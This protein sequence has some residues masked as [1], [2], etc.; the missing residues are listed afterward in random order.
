MLWTGSVLLLPACLP[1]KPA[2][3]MRKPPNTRP[4]TFRFWGWHTKMFEWLASLISRVLGAAWEERVGQW[5]SMARVQGRFII[6]ATIPCVMDVTMQGPSTKAAAAAAAATAAA[7]GATHQPAPAGLAC[8]WRLPAAAPPSA[9]PLAAL[10]EGI[11]GG[12][13][14]VQHGN[15]GSKR[16]WGSQDSLTAGETQATQSFQRARRT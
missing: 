7:S 15:M 16:S 10:R 8:S 2:H 9:L 3:R 13:L 1:H 6:P 4:C 5:W 12:C 14:T 11:T